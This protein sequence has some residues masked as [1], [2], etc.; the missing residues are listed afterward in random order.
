[1]TNRVQWTGITNNYWRASDATTDKL[2]PGRYK[3]G[4][5]VMQMVKVESDTAI[6]SEDGTA[7]RIFNDIIKFWG[8]SKTYKAYGILH[9]RGYLMHGLPGGG[10]TMTAIA[11]ANKIVAAGGIATFAPANTPIH[12]LRSCLKQV[13]EVQPDLPILNVMEDIDK[14]NKEEREAI[15]SILDGED[16]VGN[17]VHLATTNYLMALDER[18]RKRP[19]RFDE[20]ID[21]GRPNAKTRH[22]FIKQLIPREDQREDTIAVLTDA[23]DGLLF[24]HIKELVVAHMVLGKPLTETVERL[25][26]SMPTDTMP[27]AK[28]VVDYELDDDD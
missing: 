17:I 25:K 3:I 7:E 11:I 5:F 6:I 13:R 20:V 28:A 27:P 24:A 10:K 16:Q 21:L 9:K 1:M 23:S 2:P 26:A 15:L 4:P 18:F 19:S 14:Q 8:Q 22:S 12:W